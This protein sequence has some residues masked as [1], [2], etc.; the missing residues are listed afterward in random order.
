MM[1]LI[2]ERPEE[3]TEMRRT[4]KGEVIA[5][6]SD[7]DSSQHAVLAELVME[8]AKRLTE[9]GK[10]KYAEPFSRV[11]PWEPHLELP[12]RWKEPRLIFVNSMS[13]LFHDDVPLD[14]T[15]RVFDVMVRAHNHTFQVLTKRA[16]RLARVAEHL[17]WPKNVWMGV[18]IESQQYACRAHDLAKVPAAVRFLSVEPLLGPIPSLPLTG[19]H[20]VIV[21]GESGRNARP[22][23]VIWV[24][25]I[26]DQCAGRSVPFFLKQLGGRFDKRGGDQARLE[27]RLWRE[28]PQELADRASTP[29]RS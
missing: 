27:D 11:R 19:I 2:D 5:S 24:K 1:L 12:L 28:F 18:S 3:V 25:Q 10:E 22:M 26:R 20:W 15:R 14:Y 29:S 7:R 6:S 4:V 13:D 16:S 8:R 9:M 17:P 23:D 21:G